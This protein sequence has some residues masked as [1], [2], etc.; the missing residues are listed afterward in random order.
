MS[1]QDFILAP[2]TVTVRFMLAPVRNI[3]NSMSVLSEHEDCRAH[4]EWVEATASRL[5]PERQRI[6]RLTMM[7]HAYLGNE[8]TQ[9]DFPEYIDQV[10]AA[11]PLPRRDK[12]LAKYAHKLDMLPK[13]L[14]ADRKNFL[15]RVESIFGPHHRQKGLPLDLPIFADLHDLLNDPGAA[16]EMI[17]AHLRYMWQ[18]YLEEEWKRNLPA[19]QETVL[20]FQG[21]DY[22][23]QTALEVTRL[24]TGR[25]L[26]GYWFTLET[27]K[28]VAF[29]PSRHI[30]PYISGDRVED[31]VYLLFG[32]RPPREIVA[33][34]GALGRAELLARL[35]ALA[36][37]TR[38]TILELLSRHQELCAQ[39]IM[40]ILDLSQSSASRHLRQLTAAGYL[41]ERRR[42]IAKCYTLNTERVT[43]TLVA[44]Q[45]FLGG[46][47]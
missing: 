38:L 22:S 41:I 18:E 1:D 7:L 31:T 45:Q 4:G 26:A 13:T 25:D 8:Y 27:A 33:T 21:G 9:E 39:D 30:G 32:A 29:I 36:D 6:N 47:K 17:V 19:L 40:N 35:T 2:S 34:P 42:E 24:V 16:H 46:G 20:A 28:Q 23:G 43:D 3:L 14:L 5:T 12:I 10:A 15:S 11:D 44:L 37:D